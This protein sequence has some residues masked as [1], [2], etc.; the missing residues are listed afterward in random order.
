MPEQ[1]VGEIRAFLALPEGLDPD[2]IQLR[3][4][5]T[6][7]VARFEGNRPVDLAEVS[8]DAPAAGQGEAL[9]SAELPI[10]EGG[11]MEVYFSRRAAIMVN[12]QGPHLLT[13][14]AAFES[15]G[16]IQD[17][18]SSGDF[19]LMAAFEPLPGDPI[20]EL[21]PLTEAVVELEADQLDYEERHC[22]GPPPHSVWVRPSH[23][24]CPIHDLRL[25]PPDP[26]ADR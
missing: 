8:P 19:K 2:D 7:Y 15:L 24:F 9:E 23:P 5:G 16:D 3:G 6:A 13:A 4:A 11:T 14:P 10:A 12:D 22:P 25:D 17:A 18:L 21:E 20:I 26:P 1:P